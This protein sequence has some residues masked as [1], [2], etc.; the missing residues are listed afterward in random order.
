MIRSVAGPMGILAAYRDA[1]TAFS[2]SP[3]ERLSASPLCPL[4]PGAIPR[5]SD[6]RRGR[7]LLK[8]ATEQLRAKLSVRQLACCIELHDVV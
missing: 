5:S 6:E 1:R 7:A 2:L 4:A 8:V 3:A